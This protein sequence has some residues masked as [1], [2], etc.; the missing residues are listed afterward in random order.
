M[1]VAMCA[2]LQRKHGHQRRAVRISQG[3]EGLE[4]MC[5]LCDGRTSKVVDAVE[6]AGTWPCFTKM[7]KSM[8]DSGAGCRT[9]GVQATTGATW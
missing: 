2:D 6:G 4:R 3:V 8:S 7:R 1:S 5:S 9:F